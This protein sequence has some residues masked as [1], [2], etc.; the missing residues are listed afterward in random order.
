MSKT[1]FIRARGA[2]SFLASFFSARGLEESRAKRA[3]VLFLVPMLVFAFYLS[4]MRGVRDSFGGDY[5]RFMHFEKVRLANFDQVTW[6]IDPPLLFENSDFEKG[7][8][9]NWT[10][11]GEA[12][13]Y[14][15]VGEDILRENRRPFFL[16]IQGRYF[17]GTYDKYAGV[18]QGDGPEGRLVSAPFT[19]ERNKIG[20]L[21][22]GGRSD[23][24]R[25]LG[26]QA[27]VLEVEGRAVLE[28]T[29]RD[30][31]RMNLRVWDVRRWVGREARIVLVDEPSDRPFFRHLNADWFHYYRESGIRRSLPA[32]EDG[33]DGQFYYFLAHDPLLNA[34][35]DDPRRA[36]LFLD[37]P[38]Y[39]ASRIGFPLLV[40]LASLGDAA[41]FPAAMVWLVVLSHF[42]GAFFFLK[43]VLY[44]RKSPL[45]AFLYV[46]VPGFHLSLYFGLPESLCLA[47]M[48]GGLYYYLRR[49]LP[50]AALLLA[51]AVLVREMALPVAIAA[52]GYELLKRRDLR[53]A[54]WLG[55][56]VLPYAFWRAFLTFRLFGLYGWETFFQRG[57]V[58]TLPF[59]GFAELF[60]LIA[61]GS[62]RAE[63]VPTAIFYVFLLG[64]AVIFA[65]FLV[66]RTRNVFTL[67]LALYVLI[68]VSLN[69]IKMWVD[70]SN[71]IRASYE[72]FLFLVLA[73]VSQE[74][75]ARTW[76]RAGLLVFYAATLVFSAFVLYTGT[77]F[78]GALF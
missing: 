64:L 27:A 9:E 13:L 58:L 75:P 45:W 55:G 39:R 56:S 69:Y 48:L 16:N 59:A 42:A 34:V 12:F 31:E 77:F 68:A 28:E 36:L 67:G 73:F 41:R 70:M 10:P 24:E 49:R 6:N 30:L 50:A 14:Q 23:P 33:Y 61:A 71:G 38:G 25:G 20:F 76:L 44:Y 63:L 5:A 54:L 66:F 1:I 3:A 4:F 65:G 51:A 78:R 40:R 72:V 15:P 35:R 17:V 18:S 62:Y 74:K 7:A 43:I 11:E 8:L 37:H 32:A 2:V 47:F 53:A 52:A 22:G 26:R 46:L 19:I 21:L 29:G 57:D 60:R